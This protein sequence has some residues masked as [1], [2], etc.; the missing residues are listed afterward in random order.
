VGTTGLLPEP[1]GHS[2]T[3]LVAALLGARSTRR[4]CPPVEEIARALLDRVGGVAGLVRAD[5]GALTEL[6]GVSRTAAS[7]LLAAV[8]LGRRAA[9]S[10]PPRTASLSTP[11]AVAA[12]VT[13]R[14]GALDHEQ[15]WLLSL[16][17]RSRLKGLQCVALGGAHGCGVTARDILRAALRHG[18][19]CFV[20]VHN[21]PSGEPTPSFEDI[22]MT[23]A[24]ARAADVVGVP[25][26]DHVIVTAAGDWAS[27]LDEGV[28]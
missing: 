11:A 2:D 26:V 3:E 7:R 28:L 21:H 25:L 5:Q 8:E 12:F 10:P 27:L 16:D 1:A 18:A 15:M 19:S 22:E 23:R 17:G 6:S 14:L 24:V 13:P 20:L 4:G 9:A